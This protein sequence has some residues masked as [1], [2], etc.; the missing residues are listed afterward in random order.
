MWICPICQN[1]CEGDFCFKCGHQRVQ[2]GNVNAPVNSTAA[3]DPTV[4]E[5]KSSVKALK[6]MCFVL[7][8]VVAFMSVLFALAYY[9]V[10]E[11]IVDLWDN[12]ECLWDNAECLWEGFEY[13]PYGRYYYWY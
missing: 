2:M 1:R 8:G 6:I 12:V 9:S 10:W 11:N 5:L 7:I 13:L 3:Y 4:A